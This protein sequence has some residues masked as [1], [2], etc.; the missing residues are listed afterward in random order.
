MTRIQ[1]KWK[2]QKQTAWLILDSL[3]R[4]GPQNLPLLENKKGKK[5]LSHASVRIGV[6][7]LQKRHLVSVIK[8]DNSIPRRPIKTFGATKLGV[9]VW[10]VRKTQDSKFSI[11][12]NHFQYIREILPILSRKWQSLKSYYHEEF[13]IKLLAKV[14]SNIEILYSN[15]VILKYKTFYR[16]VTMEFKNTQEHEV[17]HDIHEL[18]DSAEF[19]KGFET[20][21]N[22]G[23]FLELYKLHEIESYYYDDTVGLK[24]KSKITDWLDIVKS[25]EQ[26]AKQ[27]L[28][29]FNTMKKFA[30]KTNEGIISDLEFIQGEDK[31]FC[32]ICG[33]IYDKDR[34]EE[35]TALHYYKNKYLKKLKSKNAYDEIR[36]NISE[37]LILQKIYENLT[38]F[39]RTD[40]EYELEFEK[41]KVFRFGKFFS[42]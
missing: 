3:T 37:N 2:S 5:R 25:D 38:L 31:D 34:E 13:M 19:K 30:E 7:Q 29:G 16:G 32:W 28:L 11:K 1:G 33:N 6:E 8:V 12:A 9:L 14:I 22:F 42:V 27:I 18:V 39:H 35:H 4:K 17:F 24:D 20:V 41:N 21:V 23:F 36:R 10:F 26:L 15:P 40:Y